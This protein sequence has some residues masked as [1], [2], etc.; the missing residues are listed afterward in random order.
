MSRLL[1]NEPQDPSAARRE[2]YERREGAAL[3]ALWRTIEHLKSQGV[4]IGP[5]AEQELQTRDTIKQRLP[6]QAETS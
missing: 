2:A 4:D 3:H 1:T 6:K 5:D